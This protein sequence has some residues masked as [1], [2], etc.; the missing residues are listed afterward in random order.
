VP[1]VAPRA[2]GVSQA[3]WAAYR[4]EGQFI[5]PDGRTVLL[6]AGLTAGDPGSN[7][8]LHQVPAIRAAVAAVAQETGATGYGS[9]VTH[10]P[11]TT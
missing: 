7:A 9:P 6:G 10:P 4:T 1:A 5:S 3:A 11:A 2:S 8:A